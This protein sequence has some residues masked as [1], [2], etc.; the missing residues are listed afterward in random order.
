[1]RFTRVG[2]IWGL[3]G[4]PEAAGFQKRIARPLFEIAALV[5]RRS[6]TL[7]ECLKAAAGKGADGGAYIGNAL[8]ELAHSCFWWSLPG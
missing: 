1:M 8:H 6:H 5:W 4:L 2:W 3:G 7:G